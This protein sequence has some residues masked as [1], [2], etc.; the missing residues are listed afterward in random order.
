MRTEEKRNSI[1]IHLPANLSSWTSQWSAQQLGKA[2]TRAGDKRVIVDF[3]Q[4]DAIPSSFAAALLE[5]DNDNI[6]LRNI[7]PGTVDLLDST[8]LSQAFPM[9]AGS[10]GEDAFPDAISSHEIASLRGANS[11][12]AGS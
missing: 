9:G 5:L 2:I 4:V 7:P 12:G 10:F 11:P 3:S 1:V 8:R 6:Y